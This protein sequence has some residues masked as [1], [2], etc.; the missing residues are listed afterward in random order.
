[1][2]NIYSLLITLLSIVTASA[3]IATNYSFASSSSGSMTDMSSGTT[4][5]IGANQ[6]DVASAVIDIDFDFW[7]M[8]ARYRQFSVN[9]NGFVEL[10]TFQIFNYQQSLGGGVSRLITALGGDLMTSTTGK[11]HYKMI[12]SA[13]NRV[14][15]IEFKNMSIVQPTNSADGTYQVRLYESSNSFELVYGTMNR[16]DSPGPPLYIGFSLGNV[17][18]YY[19]TYVTSTGIFNNTGGVAFQLFPL[20][21]P[22]FDLTSV[23]NGSRKMFTFSPIAAPAP[24]GLNFTAVKAVGMTLNWT[25]NS[26]D[27]V[28]Y[29]I[30]RSDDGGVTYKFY[31][32]TDNFTHSL[33]V[34]E[35]LTP[36]T[37]YFWKVYT[38]REG[39]S[40]PITG[41]LSTIAAGNITS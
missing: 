1:M 11:V 23:A 25:D 5:L 18:N 7:F 14:L 31:A 9:S 36:L 19:A 30:Y 38:V 35:G 26:S 21:A 16:N 15:V 12:G 20:S 10:G 39:L 40:S 27:E 28:G 37:N 2:K 29:A 8:G 4:Q 17:D 13:P 41:S 34:N 33:V 6:E 24:S 32:Q 3:Q 22:I